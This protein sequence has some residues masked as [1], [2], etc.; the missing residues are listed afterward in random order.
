MKQKIQRKT[1]NVIITLNQ[2]ELQDALLNHLEN[3]GLVTKADGIEF[4]FQATRGQDGTCAT[5]T[6]PHKQR[7]TV[8]LAPVIETPVAVV[9]AIPAPVETP[10]AVEAPVDLTTPAEEAA[11]QE[12]P[13]TT[14]RSLF[15]NLGQPA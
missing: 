3:Q 9:E 8:D 12:A 6:I 2:A 14:T 15:R 13:A 5:I 1:K 4:S 10:A 11:T 7:T